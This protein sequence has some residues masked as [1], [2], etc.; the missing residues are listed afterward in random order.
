[1][2]KILK[3]AKPADLPIE[4]PTKFEL[5]INLK[6]AKQ[7]GLTIPPSVLAR[8]DRVI[9]RETVKGCKNDFQ[10]KRSGGSLE[11]GFEHCEFFQAEPLFRIKHGDWRRI[12]VFFISCDEMICGNSFSAGELNV[13]FEIGRR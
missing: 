13:V 3:G 8:A 7:V 11:L 2:N 5:V 10:P 1:M 9:Q 4:Q 12:K 6:T